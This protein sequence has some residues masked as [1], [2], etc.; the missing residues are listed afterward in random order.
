MAIA[1]TRRVTATELA[2]NLSALLGEIRYRRID[3]EVTKGDEVIARVV[4]P[5]VAPAGCLVDRLDELFRRLPRLEPDEAN[6]FVADVREARRSLV[7]TESA[8]DS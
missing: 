6:A 3:L 1:E 4:P 2:R 5:D 7:E 8:W